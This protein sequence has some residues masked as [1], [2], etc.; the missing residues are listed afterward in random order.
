MFNI[1]T[2]IEN[3][4]GSKVVHRVAHQDEIVETKRDTEKRWA[5]TGDTVTHKVTRA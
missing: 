4:E 3:G 5:R 1:Q 2:T